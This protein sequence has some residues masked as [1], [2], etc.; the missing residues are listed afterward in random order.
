MQLYSDKMHLSAGKKLTNF[1]S[2]FFARLL[3]L[4][5]T[6]YGYKQEWEPQAHSWVDIFSV[7]LPKKHRFWNINYY[8]L[9]GLKKVYPPIAKYNLWI[10]NC[11]VQE[12]IQ[13]SFQHSPNITLKIY[14]LKKKPYATK[15]NKTFYWKEKQIKE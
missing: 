1:L 10:D 2:R 7:Q 6:I 9:L 11:K 12:C 14:K 5:T 15:A 3:S 4:S 13:S 8:E